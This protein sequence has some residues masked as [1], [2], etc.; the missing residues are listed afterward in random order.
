MSKYTTP[1]MPYVEARYQFGR[2]KP[3]RIILRGTFTTSAKGAALG[4]AQA[5]HSAPEPWKSGHYTVDEET[6]FRCIPDLVI[7]GTKAESDKGTLRVAICAEPVSGQRF[8]DETLHG[9]VLNRTAKL[10]A[11]LTLAYNI[12]VRY[13]NEDDR[14]W[15]SGR[16]IYVDTPSGWPSETFLAEV[17]AQRVLKTHI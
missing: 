15:W 6:R 14:G 11:E 5:W 4:L 10:V 13:I 17:N 1:K 7:A 9:R 8:W 16:G 12:P 2:Q 3:R